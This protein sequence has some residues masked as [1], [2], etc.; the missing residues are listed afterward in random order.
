MTTSPTAAPVVV[1]SERERSAPYHPWRSAQRWR[2]APVPEGRLLNALG[3]HAPWHLPR[4]HEVPRSGGGRAIPCIE[5]D[6]GAELVAVGPAARRERHA[7]EQSADLVVVQVVLAEV[8]VGK[9]EVFSE[10]QP[11]ERMVSLR[12]VLRRA[13]RS[14]VALVR[15]APRAGLLH[16]VEATRRPRRERGRSDAQV[17]VAP[18]VRR[19]RSAM[20]GLKMITSGSSSTS[21]SSPSASRKVQSWAHMP[22]FLPKMLP[23]RLQDRSFVRKLRKLTVKFIKPSL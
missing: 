5:D 2:L 17:L 7:A 3:P 10:E 12:R 18:R 19:F 22:Q 23:S 8:H 21:R 4:S 20:T 16:Q 15:Q 6:V 1:E 14:A 13:P 9:D 11:A